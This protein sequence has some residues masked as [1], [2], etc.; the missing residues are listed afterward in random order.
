MKRGCRKHNTNGSGITLNIQM[1]KLII[2]AWI[3]HRDYLAPLASLLSSLK[4]LAECLLFSFGS[5]K[6][7]RPH[8]E[9]SSLRVH[10]VNLYPINFYFFSFNNLLLLRKVEK[11]SLLVFCFFFVTNTLNE[12]CVT[13][14]KKEKMIYHLTAVANEQNLSDFYTNAVTLC[15]NMCTKLFDSCLL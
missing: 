10:T 13:N 14:D 12:D 4:S 11:N 7:F 2:Y 3:H 5:I 8:N 1:G 9:T 6:K 15:V